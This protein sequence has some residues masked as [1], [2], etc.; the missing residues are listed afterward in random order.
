[1]SMK[2]TLFWNST[3]YSLVE[4]YPEDGG[5]TLVQDVAN[6]HQTLGHDIL[7]D[8]ILQVFHRFA[9][10]SRAYDYFCVWSEGVG[11]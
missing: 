3:P 6:I 9:V 8:S 1:M 2:V 10:D 11:E 4:D 5:S 7:E